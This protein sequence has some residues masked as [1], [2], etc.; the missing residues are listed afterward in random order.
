V[1]EPLPQLQRPHTVT[2]DCWSTL[3]YHAASREGKSGRAQQ[4]SELLGSDLGATQQALSEAWRQHQL[5]W[6]QRRVFGA[7]EMVDYALGKLGLES[8]PQRVDSIVRAL[9]PAILELDVRQ[10][11]GAREALARLADRGVHRA[12]ICD[13]GFSSGRVVRQLLDRQGLLELLEVTVFSEEVGVPK[14]HPRAFQAALDGLG[15]AKEEAVHVG[16]LKRSDIAGAKAFGM[17]TV[18]LTAH[19]DD[20]G[21][22][23]A[24]GVIGCR[25]A[26]CEPPCPRP[27]ADAVVGS[28]A[29]L[30]VRL[31]F[32]SK[33]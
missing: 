2:F 29:E 25:A 17:G 7:P 14:P 23:G 5:A 4:L 26:G 12:L 21:E 24:A 1:T 16:D 3:L 8:T 31:G 15:V 33:T 6:H 11:P 30:L 22:G 28:Y 9:E 18:R 20:R 13:T 32:G 10:V 19:H 27:E